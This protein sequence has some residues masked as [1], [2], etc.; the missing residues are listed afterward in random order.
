MGDFLGGFLFKLHSVL[1]F[2]AF[3]AQNGNFFLQAFGLI[4]GFRQGQLQFV[5]E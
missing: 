5:L 3:R 2:T 4:R 1:Q